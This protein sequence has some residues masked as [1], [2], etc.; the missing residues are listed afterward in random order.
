MESDV[1]TCVN[2]MTVSKRSLQAPDREGAFRGRSIFEQSGSSGPLTGCCFGECASFLSGWWKMSCINIAK[3]LV[4]FSNYKS[5]VVHWDY[6]SC[7][8]L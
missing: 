8:H 6:K 7:K 3:L 5:Y 2:S 1:L 4:T